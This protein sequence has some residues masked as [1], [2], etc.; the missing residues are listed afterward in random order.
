[1]VRDGWLG[2]EGHAQER[3][4]FG[5][6]LHTVRA[7]ARWS[8][9]RPCWPRKFLGS[10]DTHGAVVISR[11]P[12]GLPLEPV[13]SLRAVGR[14]APGPGAEPQLFRRIQGQRDQAPRDGD[15]VRYLLTNLPLRQ[16]SAKRIALLYRQRWPLETACPHLA[17]SFHAERNTWAYPQAA[18]CGF[19][20]AWVASNVGA[21]GMAAWHSVHGAETMDQ[22]LS[23]YYV[24]TAIAQTS[25]GLRR[26]IPED[27]WRV[28]SRLRPAEM[29]APLRAWAQ[30]VRLKAYRN[31]SR[32][33]Q[34][35]RPQ[36][37]G[38]PPSSHVSTARML[39]ERQGNVATP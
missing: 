31:R 22:A 23:L 4:L 21:G 9:D 37:A 28:F 39:R 32:G 6:V 34:K 3:S 18:W 30:Q 13:N 12:E 29:V 33:P 16:A 36:R 2:E 24:A 14:L 7:G 38:S 25:H 15:R 35:P 8:A 19:G 26:A 17:A 27:A 10:V 20:L 11:Q 5:E 1:M